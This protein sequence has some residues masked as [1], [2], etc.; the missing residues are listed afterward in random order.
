MP[1]HISINEKSERELTEAAHC[2]SLPPERLAQLF[3][4]DGLALYR[5]SPDEFK[6]TLDGENQ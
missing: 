4:E 5:R 2:C 6:G 3:V 1:M